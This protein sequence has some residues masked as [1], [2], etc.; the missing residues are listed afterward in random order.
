V[1]GELLSDTGKSLLVKRMVS[2]FSKELRV[3]APNV[4][5][6][7]FVDEMKSLISEFYQYGVTP[8]GLKEMIK[9]SENEPVLY[10]KLLDVEVVYRAFSEFIE[11]KFLATETVSDM[12]AGV[13]EESSLLADCDVFFDGFTGFTPS[14]YGLLTKLFGKAN[15]CYMTLTAEETA[16]VC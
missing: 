12:L 2:R 13:I 3:F 14:Q 1:P 4:R 6:V 9:T 16:P 15:H 7:G 11:G 5:K 10:R 8:E